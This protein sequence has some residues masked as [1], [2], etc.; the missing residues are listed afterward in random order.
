MMA[1][2]IALL[3]AC[4]HREKVKKPEVL[5]TEQQMI[6]VMTDSYLLEAKLNQKK[7]AGEDV[8]SLQRAYYDRMF[9]HYGITDS[10][11]E[12]NIYYYTHELQVMER[13]MDSVL[14]RFLTA[15]GQ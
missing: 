6:D 13:I 14:N 12:A 11:F 3:T 15:Q 7:S 1:F 4:N 5:L 2:A 9:D 8:S 10:I